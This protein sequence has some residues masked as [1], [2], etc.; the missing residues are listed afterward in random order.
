[1]RQEGNV[2]YL[3]KNE[4]FYTP[5]DNER[6]WLV[7]GQIQVFITPWYDAERTIDREAGRGMELPVL[8]TAG[9]PENNLEI[10]AFCYNDPAESHSWRFCLKALEENTQLEIRPD[11]T[12]ALKRKFLK[13]MGIDTFEQEG[14]TRGHGFE[15]SLISWYNGCLARE[16][17]EIRQ[18]RSEDQAAKEQNLKGIAGGLEKEDFS[19]VK[20]DILYQTVV[21]GAQKCGIEYVE[22]FRNVAE[23]CS[24]R[25]VSV[26][27]IA[28][29]SHFICREVTLDMDWYR[30]DS[31]VIIA[32]LPEQTDDVKAKGKEKTHPVACY[33]RGSRYYCF[34]GETK[35]EQVL[36]KQVADTLREKAY[37]IRRPLPHRKLTKKDIVTFVRKGLHTR[38]LVHLIV[39]SVLSTVIGVLLPKLNQLIYDDYIPMGN[40]DVLQQICLVI[41]A[42]MI[43]NVFI[44]IVKALQEFRIPSR[45]GYELQDA[46]YQRVFELPETFFRAYDS[47]E[48]ANRI[49]GVSS[50]ANTVVSRILTAGFPLVISI[51]Y[52]IQMAGYSGKLT[53][54]C[55]L[56]L[57]VFGTLVYLLSWYSLRDIKQMEEY[58]SMADSRLYQYISGIDKIRMAGA[59]ERAILEYSSPVVSEKRLSLKAARNASLLSILMEAGSTVFSMV[60]YYMM[61]KSNIGISMG[62]FLAFTTAF[63]SVSA[64]TM[65]F[66]QGAVDYT[67]LK[68]AMQRVAPVLETAPEDEEGKNL[69]TELKGSVDVENVT[70]SYEKGQTP[71]IKGL[72]MQVLPGEYVAIVGASGCGKSTLLKL[73]LGF[74]TPDQGRILYDGTDL[75][76]LNKHSL[77]KKLGVVLQNGKLI[78]GSILEN[79]TIT[80]SNPDLKKA[81]AVIEEVGL[82]ADIDAMPMGIHTMLNETGGTISGGQQQRILIA[83]AIYNDPAV[84]FFD[85][86]TSALD[87]MTQAK[88]CENLEAR[89]MTRIVIAHRLSTVRKCDR[90]YVMDQGQIVETGNFE[91]LMRLKGR[92]YEMAIRQIV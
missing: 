23:A 26:P 76:A 53:I 43:G 32:F 89:R 52:W 41:L 14:G 68:P 15:N 46:V 91:E 57:L 25:E 90:I 47:A 74:E 11:V 69:V 37:S 59:E 78:S 75:A 71:V 27:D 13:R 66:V 34:D 67:R 70:F 61:I 81:S 38:D 7:S 82:K 30:H 49:S 60:L 28:R 84:L 65:G 10:P 17:G 1:M 51:I 85:E 33:L 29:I 55:L 24:G 92:F 56:M 9:N 31:G 19:Q 16:I 21:Y 12:M 6:Y 62:A 22:A 4:Q 88:V 18:G 20:G 40:K 48:L 2:I 3:N 64:A 44:S 83:R 77:R 50:V 5:Y 39:L 73:L 80:S 87:N 45:A 63:G 86:A 79:I 8:F 35:K 36:T 58:S 54:A 72:S 42:C